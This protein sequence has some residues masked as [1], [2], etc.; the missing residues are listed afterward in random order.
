[1]KLNESHLLNILYSYPVSENSWPL[2]G[3]IYPVLSNIQRRK[4]KTLR[5]ILLH[6]NLVYFLHMSPQAAIVYN[7][8]TNVA[9]FA[10][11]FHTN[12]HMRIKASGVGKFCYHIC[13]KA[14]IPL[15]CGLTGYELVVNTC[16]EMILCTP[17]SYTQ[18]PVSKIDKISVNKNT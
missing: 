9:L 7:F 2:N 6:C 5:Y 13:R 15:V 1:M 8:G 11:P 14:T 18:T 3:G 12:C 10:I 16:T 17:S 4:W